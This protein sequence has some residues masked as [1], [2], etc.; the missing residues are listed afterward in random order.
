MQRSLWTLHATAVTRSSGT[1]SI[2]NPQLL[3]NLPFTLISIHINQSNATFRPC[4][5]NI[6]PILNDLYIKANILEMQ[7]CM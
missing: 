7:I 5:N 6:C 1:T 3:L 4:G 2:L